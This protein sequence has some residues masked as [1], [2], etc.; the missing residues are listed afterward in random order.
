MFFF[1]SI[2]YRTTVKESQIEQIK[3][4]MYVERIALSNCQ[5]THVKVKGWNLGNGTIIIYKLS[6]QLANRWLLVYILPVSQLQNNRIIVSF[7][8][9]WVTGRDKNRNQFYSKVHSMECD[10]GNI[11][12][13]AL[14]QSEIRFGGYC[15]LRNANLDPFVAFV[16]LSRPL[17]ETF[18]LRLK[19]LCECRTREWMGGKMKK[20]TRTRVEYRFIARSIDRLRQ[21]WH[22]TRGGWKWG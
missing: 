20:K 5:L 17:N 18:E 3:N 21:G 15:T 9:K 16:I 14:R 19:I 12:S 8:I 2:L 13:T 6:N 10:D 7:L 4:N 22:S 11:R 1:Q